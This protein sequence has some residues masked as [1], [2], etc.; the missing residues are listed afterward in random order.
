M[1]HKPSKRKQRRLGKLLREAR[2]R[3][4]LTLREVGKAVGVGPSTVF[5]YEAG[6]T[7][8]PGL[9]LLGIAGV[10]GLD[11]EDVWAQIYA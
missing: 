6:T 4:G 1:S 5:V 2:L 7:D 3:R 8:P 10:L 9:R 11:L